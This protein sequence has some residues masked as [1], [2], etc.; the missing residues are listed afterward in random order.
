MGEHFLRYQKK[1]LQKQLANTSYG[2]FRKVSQDIGRQFGDSSTQSMNIMK[3]Q[4][5]PLQQRIAVQQQTQQGFAGQM[6]KQYGD[7]RRQE[8]TRQ[9]EL[10]NRLA[11][12]NAQLDNIQ[13]QKDNAWKQTLFQAGGAAVGAVAGLLIPGLDPMMGAQI[14]AGVGQA[15]GGVA[16][17]EWDM[18]L[19]GV[20]QTIAG[21]SEAAELKSSRDE[22]SLLGTK[23]AEIRT[24]VNDGTITASEAS[25]Q[26]QQLSTIMAGGGDI[27]ELLTNFS[28]Q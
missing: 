27:T 1:A 24:A 20:G 26:T 18:A 2:G 7:I 19:A 25:Y 17:E 14:V 5:V 8:M 10:S 28:L 6:G 15:A 21:I 23:M 12:T 4:G 22:A 11:Q 16:T 3:R 13:E 9:N